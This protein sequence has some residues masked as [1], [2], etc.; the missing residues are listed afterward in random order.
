MAKS[1][2][3]KWLHKGGI[4]RQ[5]GKAYQAE[6]NYNTK[7]GCFCRFL[8]RAVGPIPESGKYLSSPPPFLYSQSQF[9]VQA[10]VPTSLSYRGV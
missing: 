10:M 1:Y 5:R 3:R 8:R 2:Q 9:P 4:I 6:I 7:P